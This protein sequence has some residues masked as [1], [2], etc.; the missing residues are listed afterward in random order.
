MNLN[1]D[2]HVNMNMNINHKMNINMKINTNKDTNFDMDMDMDMSWS[3]SPNALIGQ[4]H[5][6]LWMHAQKHPYGYTY[7]Y[8]SMGALTVH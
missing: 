6:F 5:I 1:M 4:C 3:M 2:M 7:V 8:T